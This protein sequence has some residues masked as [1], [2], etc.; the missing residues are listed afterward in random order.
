[1]LEK[2]IEIGVVIA[3]FQVEKLTTAHKKLL[4][5]VYANH[6]RMIVF[7]GISPAILSRRDPLNYDSRRMMVQK[8]YPNSEIIGIKDVGISNKAWSNKL[9]TSINERYP[10]AN[11]A[12]YGGRDNFSKRYLGKYKVI[13]LTIAIPEQFSEMGDVSGTHERSETVFGG[14]R[15]SADFRAG[16]IYAA[17]QQYPKVFATVDIAILEHRETGWWV[18]LGQRPH[19]AD[20]R[21]PGGFT[22]PTDE[23]YEAAA[24]REAKEET[25]M[26]VFNL[27]YITSRQVDDWRYP[28]PDRIVTTLFATDIFDVNPIEG[29]DD[30]TTPQWYSVD[31]LDP[32]RI[33]PEHRV[34]WT[35]LRKYCDEKTRDNQ[36]VARFEAFKEK[37]AASKKEDKK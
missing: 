32:E 18:I 19:N 16:V 35:H 30:L 15:N 9:D 24:I 6:P 34:L 11:V 31:D 36:R 37:V 3:R 12:L 13:D 7:L 17:Y 14:P 5:W 28:G 25:N 27:E 4:D 8:E 1:M 20:L 2:N 21:F 26:A 29:L 10:L 33:T 23:S 22:D